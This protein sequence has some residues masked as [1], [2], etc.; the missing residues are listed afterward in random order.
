MVSLYKADSLNNDV[1]MFVIRR[2]G[3]GVQIPGGTGEGN[4]YSFFNLNR[5]FI[6]FNDI[7]YLGRG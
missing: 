6:S 7:F 2:K 1:F 5:Y 4:F 3:F